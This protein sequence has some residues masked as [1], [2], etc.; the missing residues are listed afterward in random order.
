MQEQGV[1][2]DRK[3]GIKTALRLFAAAMCCASAGS[4]FAAP[5]PIEGREVSI[6]ARELPIAGFLQDLFGQTGER[7]VISPSVTGRVNGAF[8]G[9]ADEVLSDISSAFNLVPYYDGAVVYIYSGQ[10]LQTQTLTVS[11]GAAARIQRVAEQL[12]LPD[13]ANNIRTAN[14]LVIVNG[15]PR[16]LEQ[17]SDIAAAEMQAAGGAAPRAESEPLA[18]RVFYLKHAWAQDVTLSFGGERVVIPGVASIVRSLV[19]GSPADPSAALASNPVSAP[20]ARSVIDGGATYQLDARGEVIGLAAPAITASARGGF[21]AVALAG[22]AGLVRVQ[23]DPRLNAVIVRDAENRLPVYE[24]LIDSLDRA[25]Q[26]IEIKA[27][28]IDL[29]IDRLRELGV[30]WRLSDAEGENAILFGDGA[31]SDLLLGPDRN[32]TPSARGL[33]ISTVIGDNT[34]FAARINAL[35]AEGAANIVSRP[36]VLTLDN[37]EAI[38]DNSQTF[39]V[40]VAGEREVDLFNISAGT[41]LRVTPHVF[42]EGGDTQIRLLVSIEDG[43]LT[44][45]SVDDIPI[46]R[47]SSINTQAIIVEG[48]S[49]LLGGLT[50]DASEQR[51]DKVP[52]LGD[53]PMLGALFRDTTETSGRVERLFMITPRLVSPRPAGPAFS[54]AAPPDPDAF[55]GRST[56]VP[57]PASETRWQAAAPA[58]AEW[59]P[60]IPADALP[61]SPPGVLPA[62]I[63]SPEPSRSNDE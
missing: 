50:S 33:A 21:E 2:G 44:A 7:V 38:F 61:A 35:E 12:G 13:A 41:T 49:L 18:F 45:S 34:Y 25:P 27:T 39:F 19:L 20:T 54:E 40:R 5:P 9:P 26:L 36:Q 55:S 47:N 10:D 57:S 3:P 46:L 8:E 29:N 30:S 53:V 59:R 11:P 4:A 15:A 6:T 31:S 37:V 32:V 1:M 56:P 62:R 16:F 42:T 17:I 28:I 43:R 63:L 60:S 52:V 51:V 22:D 23:A 24:G 58:D 14:G 48:E